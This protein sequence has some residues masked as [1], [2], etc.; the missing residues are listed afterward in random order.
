M[1]IR[2]SDAISTSLNHVYTL[3]GLQHE[4]DSDCLEKLEKESG[5]GA[6]I[7]GLMTKSS[8]GGVDRTNIGNYLRTCKTKPSS[9]KPT[10]GKVYEIEHPVPIELATALLIGVGY[11][12]EKKYTDEQVRNAQANILDKMCEIFS[13]KELL[14]W[15]TKENNG[16]LKSIFASMT[17]G[18]SI[19]NAVNTHITDPGTRTDLITYLQTS[20]NKI[21]DLFETSIS[22][23][24]D[25]AIKDALQYAKDICHTMSNTP[26]TNP[27]YEKNP[28]EKYYGGGKRGK[29]IQYGG[30]SNPINIDNTLYSILDV[31]DG[32]RI[33]SANIFEALLVSPFMA[34]I[35]KKGKENTANSEV[36]NS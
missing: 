36:T 33:L 17:S 24:T 32:R 5:L 22:S 7:N 10:N 20:Y 34:E 11:R 25:D 13:D 23:E 8:G 21:N 27:G 26:D 31:D 14:A 1:L 19:K 12:L 3:K 18:L 28:C 35:K 4:L 9:P 6:Y 2:A 29:S 30:N 15:I 16:K